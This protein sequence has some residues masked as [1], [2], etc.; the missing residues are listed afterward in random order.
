MTRSPTTT[1]ARSLQQ[2]SVDRSVDQPVGGMNAPALSHVRRGAVV[3]A[4]VL[5]RE[6]MMF[7]AKII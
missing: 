2:R 7:A 4:V 1:T 5:R 6:V 3:V